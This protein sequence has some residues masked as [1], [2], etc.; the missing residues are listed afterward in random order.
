MQPLLL[1]LSRSAG[2]ELCQRSPRVTARPPPQARPQ[3]TKGKFPFISTSSAPE[4]FLPPIVRGS[5]R[6][7][8]TLP[9]RNWEAGMGSQ[10][11][12]RANK[13]WEGLR[14]SELCGGGEG[15]TQRKV[16]TPR[17]RGSHKTSPGAASLAPSHTQENLR[18][19]DWRAGGKSHRAAIAGTGS[20]AR[21]GTVRQP[22]AAGSFPVLSLPL[23]GHYTRG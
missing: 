20:R 16:P 2:G 23:M 4:L 15:G 8:E 18:S 1:P 5:H 11:G 22:A 21:R 13:R 3:D 14:S 9:L 6:Q 12:D 7:R 19:T 17:A 10:R